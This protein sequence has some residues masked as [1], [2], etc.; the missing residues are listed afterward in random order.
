MSGNHPGP[1]SDL[2]ALLEE[3]KT[4]VN[5]ISKP[6]GQNPAEL[7]AVQARLQELQKGSQGWHIAD[8]L[9]ASADSDVRFFG[10]LTFTIKVN[11]DWLHDLSDSDIRSLA[12]HLVGR[13]VFLVN[14]GEKPLVTR[15]LVSTLVAI[16][17]KPNTPWN[18]V[19]WHLAV[20]LSSGQVVSEAQSLQTDFEVTA[21][22]A[23]NIIQIVSLLRFSSTLAEEALKW[24]Q[25][26]T[27]SDNIPFSENVQDAFVLCDFVLRHILHQY[28]S[29]STVTSAAAGSEAIESYHSWLTA[30]RTRRLHD[31]T[32]PVH[33]TPAAERLL[34]CLKVPGLFKAA[35]VA[36]TEILDSS[37][38]VLTEEHMNLIL[39]YLV[40]EEGTTRIVSLLGSNYEDENMVFLELLLAYSKVRQVTL[41]TGPLNQPDESVLTYLHTLFHGPGYAAVEDKVCPYM[42]DWWTEAADEIQMVFVNSP[43]FEHS[44]QNLAKTALSCFAKLQY[45]KPE[46]LVQWDDDDKSEFNSFR[47]DACDFLL[48]VYP[49]LGVDLIRVFQQYAKSALE[50]KDWDPFEAAIFCLVQLS[51]A[52]DENQ[53]ADQ[54]L[55]EF[56]FSGEFATLCA[57]EGV[58]IAPK[59]RQTLV[60]MIGQYRF[61][62]ERTLPLLPRVLTFLF[63]SLNVPPCA[64]AASRSISSLCRSC[65]SALTSELPVFFSL[66]DQFRSQ[67]S[68]AIAHT[69]E[70]VLEGIAAV[71]QALDTDEAKAEYLQRL[72]RFFQEQTVIAREEAIHNDIDGARNRGQRV[73]R[74][75]AGIGRGLRADSDGV[76]DL[77]EDSLDPH[78][79][80]FWSA[81]NGALSQT[82][83]I[84]CVHFLI[85]DF[86]VDITIIEGAC[87]I[88]K[89]GY[90][91]E[92]GPFVFSP[93]TTVD[94]IKS[95]P[96]GSAGADLVM[97]TA[98]AFLA[99]HSRHPERIHGETEALITHVYDT[100]CYM[101]KSPQNRD[102]QVANS[103][104]DFLTRLLPRYHRTLFSLTVPPSN[105]IHLAVSPDGRTDVYLPSSPAR[106]TILPTIFKFT[107]DALQGSDPLPLRSASQ[108]WT[109]IISLQPETS[110][111]SSSNE[112]QLIQHTIV[113]I[114]PTLCQVLI[115]QIAGRCARSDLDYL[116][117]VLKKLV[118]RYQ[119][120]AR[121]H[122]GTTLATLVT[123]EYQDGKQRTQQ[124]HEGTTTSED[125]PMRFLAM[126][127][128]ARGSRETNQ[129][130]RS[131]WLKCRGAVFEYAG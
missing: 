12:S 80:T 44:K 81:G 77:D 79:S 93:I 34:Q 131:F 114:I 107:L 47:R 31:L 64:L 10:A 33:L 113:E 11:Q 24:A 108:F 55:N 110:A 129:L 68:A 126:V 43:D 119:S 65:R 86:P 6:Q 66:F 106:S 5:V 3:A 112:G 40:S 1:T 103:G 29:G 92:S 35:A 42:L 18:R 85:H 121:H 118:F 56:F 71:I 41:L 50:N 49:I 62:F 82:L 9:L 27:R 22:P 63:A 23:L 46:I 100:F 52:V 89:A 88:L 109:G 2:R 78:P 102:P 75:I 37:D 16:F 39:G 91:E 60:D 26:Q 124:N 70:R 30:R 61:Y 74:S 83:I 116:S 72:L 38:E 54:C 90:T 19:I 128:A 104:I 73:L 115:T 123:R 20:S 53:H 45:P 105:P 25:D 84:Q 122:L 95:I 96:L 28:A 8:G 99:S 21:L 57:G 58:Q 15:K 76:V 87:D 69:T 111:G 120:L 101:E 7:R 125:D 17:L 14:S 67:P 127:I 36:L 51:E 97:D 32:Q 117:E 98:S 59:A 4:L 130:V 13:F 94:F 48:A